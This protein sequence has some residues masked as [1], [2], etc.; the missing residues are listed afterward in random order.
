M[1]YMWSNL[2]LSLAFHNEDITSGVSLLLL[3]STEGRYTILKLV[4][5]DEKYFVIILIN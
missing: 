4:S 5:N 2:F 1:R 3:F